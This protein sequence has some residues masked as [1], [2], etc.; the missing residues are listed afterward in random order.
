MSIVSLS[1][2]NIVTRRYE[3]RQLLIYL[4][5]STTNNSEKIEKTISTWITVILEFMIRFIKITVQ[6]ERR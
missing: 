6:W 4:Q 3:L 5:V 2:S 1:M